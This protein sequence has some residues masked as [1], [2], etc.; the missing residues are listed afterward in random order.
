MRRRG[1]T[2]IELL[3]AVALMG[4]VMVFAMGAFNVQNQTYVVIDQVSE[5]QQNTNAIARLI[6]RDIR[7]AGYLM[8]PAASACGVDST[9]TPDMLFLADTDAILPADQ[10]PVTVASDELGSEVSGGPIPTGTGGATLVVD[11]VVLDGVPTY[12]TDSDGTA[13]SDFQ[14]GGG[15]ILVDVANTDRGVACGMVTGVSLVGP[16]S[17]TVNF[18][19][20]I[21]AGAASPADVKLVPAHVYWV[22]AANPPRLLRDATAL[23]RD[24]EDLQASWFYDDDGDDV[25]DLPGETRGASGSPVLDTS[26]VDGIDLREIRFHVVVRTRADDPRNED[27]AGTGQ[28]RENRTAASAPGD[29]GKRRRVHTA[30][31]RLRNLTL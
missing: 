6:E 24:V 31:V 10:L 12:D 29:D 26:A 9:T 28:A 11:D 25:V 15:A 21:S 30:T 22:N 16:Q 27:D 7:N 23:A 4:I 2:L 17:V 18:Q 1:F 14:I 8:P 19:T 5:T 3:V 13:D 20:A